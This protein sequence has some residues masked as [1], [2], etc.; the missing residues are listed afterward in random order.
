ML[1]VRDDV[2]REDCRLGQLK[3][4]ERSD[5]QMESNRLE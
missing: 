3:Y 1:G 4:V 5:E 2:D